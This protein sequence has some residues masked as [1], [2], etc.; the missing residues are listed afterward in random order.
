MKSL[1]NKVPDERL[2]LISGTLC[3]VLVT[4]DWDRTR[5]IPQR[6]RSCPR[7]T[8]ARKVRSCSEK[9]TQYFDQETET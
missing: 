7:Q 5:D 4:S 8:S 6:Q 3:A 2:R 1:T 9:E